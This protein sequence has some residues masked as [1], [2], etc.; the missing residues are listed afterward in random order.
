MKNTESSVL[1]LSVDT[2]SARA[3]ADDVTVD[4]TAVRLL[5]PEGHGL[6]DVDQR[7]HDKLVPQRHVVLSVHLGGAIGEHAKHEP[8][9]EVTARRSAN[10]KLSGAFI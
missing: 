2:R 4:C 8:W 1:W 10:R 3:V 6:L 5:V 9:C 7:R